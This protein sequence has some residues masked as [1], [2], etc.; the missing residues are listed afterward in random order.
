MCSLGETLLAFACFILYFKTKLPCHSRYL[1][2]SYFAFQSPIMKQTSFGVLVLQGHVGLHRT[3]QHQLLQH[4]WSGHRLNYCDIAWLALET[5]R[6]H[7]VIFEIA[8]KYCIS[9]SFVNCDG[10]CI[11]SKGFLPTEVDIN[12]YLS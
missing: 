8:S 6:D 1:L 12:G 11:S 2:A 4:Y 9:D 3:I 5:G 10:Y 7:F